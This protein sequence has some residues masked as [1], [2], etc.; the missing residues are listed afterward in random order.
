MPTKHSKNASDRHHLTYGEKR[1][2]GIGSISQR[3]GSD[4]QLPFGYCPLSLV[5]IEDAVVS[6]S[7]HIY[8]REAILEYLL[9]KTQ[10]IKAQARAFEEQ[11][12]TF[13]ERL[14]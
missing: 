9:N 13:I 4:S 6:P 11:E 14:D 1:K 12:V 8:S 3:L 10:E 5:P 7:G 2:N